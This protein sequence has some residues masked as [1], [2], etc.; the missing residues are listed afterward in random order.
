MFRNLWRQPD[1]GRVQAVMLAYLALAWMAAR[2][3][4]HSGQLL[5]CTDACVRKVRD[6]QRK[7][8]RKFFGNPSLT[9][10]GSLT[11]V[12]RS[13]RIQ[14]KLFPNATARAHGA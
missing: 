9:V 11:P 5:S 10:K 14:T 1:R 7:I 4:R 8:F 3:R 6:Q 13:F 12:T 2:E